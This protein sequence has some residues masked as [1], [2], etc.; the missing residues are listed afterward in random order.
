[1]S[2]QPAF[3]GF[4]ATRHTA[5]IQNRRNTMNPV[6]MALLMSLIGMSATSHGADNLTHYPT[7]PIRMLAPE[8][9]GGNEVAARLL[10]QSLSQSLGRNIV[11]EN[12]GGASGEIAGD[13]VAHAPAD[14]YTL[15]YYGSTLWLLPYLRKNLPFNPAKDFAP[16][17]QVTYAPFFLFIHPSLAVKNVSELIEL[18]KNRPGSLN[19]GSAGSGSATHLSGELFNTLAHVHIVRVAYK[20]S[21][22]AASALLSG[23]VQLMF[24]SAAVGLNHIKSGR[25]KALAIA[26]AKPSA[27]APEVPTMTSAGLPGFEASSMSGLFA[28]AKTPPAIIRLLN[29]RVTQSLQQE[30]LK[31]QFLKIGTQAVG[32]SPEA[33]SQVIHNDT[34]KWS[35]V[36]REAGISEDIGR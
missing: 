32:N 20:G 9:G 13:I 33:F 36:I 16:I 35:K 26:S 4:I 8:P 15:L 2:L 25:L 3:N 27:L 18:A 34:I 28:P 31:Q 12:R 21:A 29:Q 5:M 11:I 22:L 17:S 30:G 24:V 19:Y 6:A 1:M 7:K 23:E 10:A 14:G